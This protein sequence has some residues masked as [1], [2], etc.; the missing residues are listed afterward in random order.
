MVS[1][2]SSIKYIHILVCPVLR[3]VEEMTIIH[4]VS[5]ELT[6]YVGLIFYVV[7]LWLLQCNLEYLRGYSEGTVQLLK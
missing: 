4:A 3:V 1:I 5:S 2:T 6:G 7:S